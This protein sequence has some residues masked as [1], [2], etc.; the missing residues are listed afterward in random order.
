MWLELFQS[1][2]CVHGPPNA[3]VMRLGPEGWNVFWIF[4]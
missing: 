1:Y 3:S 2:I 4:S